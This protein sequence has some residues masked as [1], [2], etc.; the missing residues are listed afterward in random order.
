MKYDIEFISQI[1]KNLES[2]KRFNHTQAYA[3]IDSFFLCCKVLQV[4]TNM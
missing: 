1:V 4:L 2:E 3:Y